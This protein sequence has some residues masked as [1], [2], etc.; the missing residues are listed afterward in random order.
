MVRLYQV[1]K[2]TGDTFRYPGSRRRSEI[3]AV[4]C[5]PDSISRNG[6]ATAKRSAPSD[7]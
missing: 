2:L 6:S 1:G 5:W 4:W 3:E 7:G